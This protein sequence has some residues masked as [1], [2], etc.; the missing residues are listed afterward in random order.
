MG[1]KGSKPRKPK[2]SQHLPKA[3][4]R[5]SNER[6][7]HEERQAVFD[8]VGGDRIA[9]SAAVTR[10]FGRLAYIVKPEGDLSAT[11]LRN[12]TLHGIFLTRERRRLEELTRLIDRGLVRPL[13]VEVLPL[14]QVA[15]AHER[16]DSG[17]GR[18]KLVL[19]VAR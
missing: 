11:Y 7:L 8:T 13:V 4:T 10:P 3:G 18:G 2:H 6:L 16:L 15:Q 17:H 14:E 5:P 12:L 1:S 9:D 19:D